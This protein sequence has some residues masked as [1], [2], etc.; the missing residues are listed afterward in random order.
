MVASKTQRIEMT[1][2]QIIFQAGVEALQGVSDDRL[3]QLTGFKTHTQKRNYHRVKEVI[4][5]RRATVL[6]PEQ[7]KP[8]FIP[9]P[10]PPTKTRKIIMPKP[11]TPIVLTPKKSIIPQTDSE[12][13]EIHRNNLM[14][15]KGTPIANP[16]LREGHGVGG[17]AQPFPRGIK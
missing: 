8:V 7:L 15:W 9:A 11:T 5:S 12:R 3:K 1:P 17:D 16:P 10:K 4:S 6:P 2:R 13:H 14:S